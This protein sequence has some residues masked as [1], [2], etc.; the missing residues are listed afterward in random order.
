MNIKRVAAVSSATLLTAGLLMSPAPAQASSVPST[1]FT[2]LNGHWARPTIERLAMLGIVTGSDGKA[3]PDDPMTRAE[4]VTVLLRALDI[5]SNPQAT[6]PFTDIP[7]GYWAAQSIATAAQL[8]MVNGVATGQFAPAAYIQRDAL[9]KL[10]TT[11]ASSLEKDTNAAP[12]FW[13][14]SNNWGYSYIV[15]A[16][17]TGLVNGKTDTNHY[18]PTDNATRA[19]A[20]VMIERMLQKQTKGTIPTPEILDGLVNKVNSVTQVL[21]NGSVPAG[22]SANFM[23][24]MRVIMDQVEKGQ[25]AIPSGLPPQGSVLEETHAMTVAENYI[26]MRTTTSTPGSGGERSYQMWDVYMMKQD[27]Q[28]KIGDYAAVTQ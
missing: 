16:Y 26:K 10:L 19:E 9:A 4:F 22:Y 7:A 25:A 3:R 21:L 28:W 8:Q 17:Q 1:M 24:P 12:P 11:D 14:I 5:K 6:L 20:F 15:T 2:D 13:D 23:G 27:G 18:N